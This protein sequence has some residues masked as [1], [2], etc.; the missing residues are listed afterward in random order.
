MKWNKQT[1]FLYKGFISKFQDL[2]FANLFASIRKITG[3]VPQTSQ[4]TLD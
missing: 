4:F 2:E 3:I 1:Q